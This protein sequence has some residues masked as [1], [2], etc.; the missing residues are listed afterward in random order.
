MGGWVFEKNKAS[1]GTQTWPK[2]DVELQKWPHI[3]TKIN[4]STNEKYRHMATE[5][6]CIWAPGTKRPKTGGTS[7]LEN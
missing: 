7:Y 2:R 6:I 1:L 4:K 5:N 3:Y